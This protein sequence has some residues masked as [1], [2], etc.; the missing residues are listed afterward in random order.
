MAGH[1]ATYDARKVSVVVDGQVL[2]GFGEGSFVTFSK[3][4]DTHTPSVGAQGDVTVAVN[5]NSLGTI[6]VVMGQASPFI[7]T[8]NKLANDRRIVSVWV[9]SM[10]DVKETIGGSQAMLTKPGDGEFGAENADRT[11]TFNVFDYQHK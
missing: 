8:L 7:N 3:S 10:N 11:F 6:E 1:I 4:E 2:T 5:G 9:H